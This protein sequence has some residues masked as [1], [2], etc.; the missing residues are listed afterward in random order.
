MTL[1]VSISDLPLN[2][3]Y[4]SKQPED[5]K[6]GENDTDSIDYLSGFGKSN[7]KEYKKVLKYTNKSRSSNPKIK[8]LMRII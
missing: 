4:F 8:I 2:K 6:G 1:N 5:S 3:S 7:I